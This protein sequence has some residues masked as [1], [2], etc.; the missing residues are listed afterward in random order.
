[1]R[2]S[3]VV[4]ALLCAAAAIASAQSS[5]TH[6]VVVT[7]E[8]MKWGPAPPA[9]PA[10]AEAAVLDG[11][12]SKPGLFALRVKLPDGY[13]V[14]AHWHPMDEN[15]VVLQ[16]ALLIGMGDKLDE[17]AFKALPAGSFTRMPAKVNHY[18]GAKGETIFHIYGQG[19]FELNYVSPN[20]DP[21]KKAPSAQ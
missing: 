9:L 4:F 6:H 16:G 11:D 13:R 18:A 8:A 2:R 7:P 20:D 3:L 5:P 17:K 10:G 14:A 21:R 15:L 19:P 1:M 12:P